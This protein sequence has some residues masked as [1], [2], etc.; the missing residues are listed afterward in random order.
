MLDYSREAV[1]MAK[2]KTRAELDAD[3]KLNLS[4]VR[5]LEV[6]GEAASQVPRVDRAQ[7]PAIPWPDIV[8]LRNRLIHAY[9][10]VDLK[11]VWEIVTQDLPPLIA[12]L[13]KIL[14]KEP[15]A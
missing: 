12:E 1:A 2:D 9:E 13:E 8:G 11:I 7:Y 3:R 10:K 4:L 6:V 15:G 5:L 14:E